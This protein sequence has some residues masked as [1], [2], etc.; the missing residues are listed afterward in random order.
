[1]RCAFR[2]EGG[3]VCDLRRWAHCG[4]VKHQFE[5]T[6]PG[7]TVTVLAILDESGN[8]LATFNQLEHHL[9]AQGLVFQRDAD[10]TIMR[11]IRS[12]AMRLKVHEQEAP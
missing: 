6:R 5:G 1:M 9:E 8:V 2:Y 10:D 4:V 7:G 3:F 12:N 11:W